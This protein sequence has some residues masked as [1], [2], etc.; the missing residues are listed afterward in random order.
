MKTLFVLAS[1]LFAILHP[2]AAQDHFFV[3]PGTQFFT[4]NSEN[5]D[6]EYQI[7]VRLPDSYEASSDTE[8]PVLYINDA[9][10]DMSI[11]SSIIGKLNYDRTLP[12]I[13]LVGIS[14]PG[15]DADYGALRDGDL[16]PAFD[17]LID[18]EWV[19]EG[20][21]AKYLSFI[22]E[23]LIPA[24]ESKYRA[25]PQN[26]ALGG[27]SAGGLFSLFALYERPDLFKRH[28]AIS[29]YVIFGNGYLFRRDNAYAAKHDSFPAR[30]FIAYGTAEYYLYSDPIKA[31]QKKLAAR[32]YK[33]FELLN[34]QME[35]ERH[36]GVGAEGYVRG[37]RWVFKD[38]APNEPGPLES[39]AIE[40]HKAGAKAQYIDDPELD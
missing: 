38:L 33:D 2:I 24:I 9:Q 8:Y 34:W 6:R 11:V 40:I 1:F 29:P 23:E 5:T 32:N 37:L 30:V 36:G 39:V 25:D 35:G 12:E 16:I 15:P 14:Y 28:I 18:I 10:W 31:F 27:V 13:I 4:M 7:L 17:K 19:K 21:A 26:R 22:A 3:S 20:H